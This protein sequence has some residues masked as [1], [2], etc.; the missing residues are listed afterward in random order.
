[1]KN[2]DNTPVQLAAGDQPKTM[3]QR[4]ERHEHDPSCAGCHTLMDPFG[5]ALEN[6]DA[7]GHYRELDSGLAID[8]SSTA[9]DLGTFRGPVELGTLL[10]NDARVTSCIPK[11]FFAVATGHSGTEREAPFLESLA[12]R[13]A[14]SDHRVRALLLDLV[15]SD[16]FRYGAA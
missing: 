8:A 16:A 6:F 7:T 1:P 10:R 14:A 2:V 9:D 4:L 13:F 15:T 5:L 3:R 11:N 12:N